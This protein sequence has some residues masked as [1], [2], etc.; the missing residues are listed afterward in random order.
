MTK[1]AWIYLIIALILIILITALVTGLLLNTNRAS[2]EQIAVPPSPNIEAQKVIS[3]SIGSAI[4]GGAPSSF[5]IAIDVTSLIGKKCCISMEAYVENSGSIYVYLLQESSQNL[6]LNTSYRL[7]ARSGESAYVR[8]NDSCTATLENAQLSS[9]EVVWK[10]GVFEVADS[11]VA[12]VRTNY[13]S[14]LEVNGWDAFGGVLSTNL[15]APVPSENY[16]ISVAVMKYNTDTVNLWFEENMTNLVT[17]GDLLTA[18]AGFPSASF[19]EF[20][21]RVNSTSTIE[22]RGGA[23]DGIGENEEIVIIVQSRVETRSTDVYYLSNTWGLNSVNAKFAPNIGI[24]LKRYALFDYAEKFRSYVSGVGYNDGTKFSIYENTT[25]VVEGY[26]FMIMYELPVGEVFN[27][28]ENGASAV[29]EY[30]E[31]FG[32]TTIEACEERVA[33]S[34]TSGYTSGYNLGYQEGLDGAVT[35]LANPAKTLFASVFGFIDIPIFGGFSVG[36]LL[37]LVVVLGVV[38][39]FLFYGRGR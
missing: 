20:G 1:K 10:L 8:F 6:V 14:F 13:E 23:I 12:F 38:G 3:H 19:I 22:G 16:N 4:V 28:V 25:E 29:F 15:I 27:A 18:P 2:A 32:F 24:G 33:N 34:Y 9:Y 26:P 21:I 31:Q 30:P 7:L 35:D 17:A 37:T 5:T 39:F 11:Q 36:D